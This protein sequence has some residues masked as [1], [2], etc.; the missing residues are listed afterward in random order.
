MTQQSFSACE[1]LIALREIVAASLATPDHWEE[2]Y[3][4]LTLCALRAVSWETM[5]VGSRRLMF[6]VAALAVTSLRAPDSKRGNDDG[7]ASDDPTDDIL[8]S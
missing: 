7:P 2:Y 3:V 5:M 6:L 1:P 8:D 4:S